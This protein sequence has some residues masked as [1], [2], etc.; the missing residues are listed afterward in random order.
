MK[1]HKVGKGFVITKHV[2]TWKAI[3]IA[4]YFVPVMEKMKQ[5]GRQEVQKHT[6]F[7]TQLLQI[8]QTKSQDRLDPAF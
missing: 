3:Y 5:M 2:A 7:P 1:I 4:I 6:N 8:M